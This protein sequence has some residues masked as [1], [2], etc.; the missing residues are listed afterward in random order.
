[1]ADFGLCKLI[2]DTNI[3]LTPPSTTVSAVGAWKYMAPELLR[4][5]GKVTRTTASDIYAFGCVCYEV[6]YTIF[7]SVFDSYL[8]FQMFTGNPRFSDLTHYEGMMAT[9]ENH[10]V[11]RPEMCSVDSWALIKSCWEVDPSSRPNINNIVQNLTVNLAKHRRSGSSTSTIYSQS[12]SSLLPGNH[13]KGD[14]ASLFDERS[15]SPNINSTTSEPERI[16]PSDNSVDP[17]LSAIQDG[18]IEGAE[19]R[20]RTQKPKILPGDQTKTLR[21]EDIIIA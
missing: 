6:Q 4:P 21:S 7:I 17:S 9:I 13:M 15:Q 20:L 8:P 1:M 11:S 18:I 19:V 5:T 16:T 12:M 3:L 2:E 14:E 10:A